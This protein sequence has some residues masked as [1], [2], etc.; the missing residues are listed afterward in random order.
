M[1]YEFKVW[2][3]GNDG[4]T[5]GIRVKNVAELT[6]LAQVCTQPDLAGNWTSLANYLAAA[7]IATSTPPPYVRHVLVVWLDARG[8]PTSRCFA[9]RTFVVTYTGPIRVTGGFGSQG[10]CIIDPNGFPLL[11]P[12]H[13]QLIQVEYVSDYGQ[14]VIVVLP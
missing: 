4:R 13:R 3:Q 7:R 11:G 10:Y 9:G 14:D 6:P 12:L 1:T 2:N 5:M 8:Y